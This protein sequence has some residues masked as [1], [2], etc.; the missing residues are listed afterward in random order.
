MIIAR[1]LKIDPRATGEWD[2]TSSEITLFSRVAY[3]IFSTIEQKNVVFN[4][5]LCKLG[6]TSVLKAHECQK[7]LSLLH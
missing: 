6:L 2:N 7:H 3:T 1:D 5:F 4:S